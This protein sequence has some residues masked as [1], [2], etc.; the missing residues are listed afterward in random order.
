MCD[1]IRLHLATSVLVATP[2]PGYLTVHD[3]PGLQG[4]MHSEG[5]LAKVFSILLVTSQSY[6]STVQ[7]V[8]DCLSQIYHTY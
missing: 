3:Y 2:E 5:I 4:V 6:I 8:Q 1:S 7:N